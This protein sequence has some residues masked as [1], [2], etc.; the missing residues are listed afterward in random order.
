MAKLTRERI[1]ELAAKRGARAI[2]VQNFLGSL[3]GGQSDALAN[4]ELD[5]RSYRWNAATI[6][7]IRQGIREHFQR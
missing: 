7:A 5:A 6:A 4:L 2:A 1:N 3:A